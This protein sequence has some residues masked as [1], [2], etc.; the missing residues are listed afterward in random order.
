MLVQTDVQL[1]ISE[2]SLDGCN[3]GN[4][5]GSLREKRYE[6]RITLE[7]RNTY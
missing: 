7:K 6:N 5:C 3:A 4:V 1:E 2:V